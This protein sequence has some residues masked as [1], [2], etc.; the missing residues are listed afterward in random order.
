VSRFT[1]PRSGHLA[2]I[3]F[4]GLAASC[5]DPNAGGGVTIDVSPAPL[6]VA[7]L[8][9]GRLF[10]HVLNIDGDTIGGHPYQFVP[11]D[12]SMVSVDQFGLVR[13]LGPVGTT[14][15]AISDPQDHAS[16]TAAVDITTTPRTV[17][18]TP[19]DTAIPPN[20]IV[21]YS[22]VVYD[23]LG[24]IPRQPYQLSVPAD[25]ILTPVGDSAVQSLGVL[26]ETVVT[27]T[28]GAV[29]GHAAVS[30]FDTLTAGR[31][32]ASGHPNLV[33]MDRQGNGYVTR[34]G[35]TFL[36][37]YAAV[38]RRPLASLYVPLGVSSLSLDTAG[39]RAY[40]VG[41]SGV[42]G[43]STATGVATD[44]IHTGVQPA[45]VGVAPDD[46]TI[47]VSEVGDLLVAFNRGTHHLDQALTLTTI[48][49]FA[50]SP[51][52][53]TLLYGAI[54]GSVVEINCRELSLGRVFAVGGAVVDLAVSADGGT[55]FAADA[56]RRQVE[57]W[58]LVTGTALDSVPLAASPGGLG[59]APD[60][61]EL[62]VTL[63]TLGEVARFNPATLTSLGTLTTHG[64]PQGVGIGPAGT[65]GIVA[66]DSGWVDVVPR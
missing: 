53:D 56:S 20:G 5:G 63:P 49:R 1:L 10:V 47:W 54:G 42:Y 62:W 52:G 39:D 9:T 35:T 36:T 2:A 61:G 7:R 58:N 40:V 21:Q 57:V 24:A 19:A 13:S 44:T 66:N 27:V 38:S 12:P 8:D 51:P 11:Q 29:S 23:S 17:L 14:T 37:R 6:F 64:K 30:V 18:V 50:A 15:I 16:G 22:V 34:G 45:A 32:P 33:A 28:S 26:G 3:S 25:R 48:S 41:P 59:L 60:G 55:L 65:V 46:K 43:I 4:L 31:L